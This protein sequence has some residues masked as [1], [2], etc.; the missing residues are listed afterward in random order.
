MER[1]QIRGAGGSGVRLGYVAEG[2][3]LAR[4]PIVVARKPQPE[5]ATA[6]QPDRIWIVA[7]QPFEYPYDVLP[8]SQAITAVVRRVP[9][10]QEHDTVDEGCPRVGEEPVPV[11][12]VGLDAER[13]V[14]LAG[15]G[16][17]RSR[18]DY[19]LGSHG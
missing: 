15:P 19:F 9:P 1:L 5:A 12:D 18:L 17:R 4:D 6:D 7:V 10:I 14:Q 13:D 16:E 8:T 3:M 2:E 11:L